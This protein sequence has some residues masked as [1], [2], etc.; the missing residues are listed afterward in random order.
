MSDPQ[1]PAAAYAHLLRPLVKNR[2]GTQADFAKAVFVSTSHLSEIL[3]GRR[4][5]SVK[6]AARIAAEF[7]D[8]PELATLYAEARNFKLPALPPALVDLLDRMAMV[9]RELPY[10]LPSRQPL[11]LSTLYVRQSVSSPAEVRWPREELPEEVGWVE[12]TR[13]ASTLAQPFQDVFEQNDHLVIEGGAGLGKTTLARQL[14]ADLV[15]QVRD[16]QPLI[17]LLLSARVLAK[18]IDGRS[19]GEA[20][21]ASLT[22]EYPGFSDRELRP[23]LFTQDVDGHRWM[24]VVDALDEIPDNTARDQLI[25]LIAGRMGQSTNSTRF[26]ITTRPLELGET[27]RLT[28]AGFFELQPFD[29]EA[30]KRFA[31][32][33]F[34]PRDTT[35]GVVAAD[36]F[37]EQVRTAGLTDVLEVPLL[38]AIA[39]NVHQSDPDSPL[40]ASRYELYVRYIKSYAEMRADADAQALAAL[41]GDDELAWRIGEERMPLLE[42]L[43]L[44][45]MTTETP[46]LDLARDHLAEKDLLPPRRGPKWED[47]LAEWL[48][49]TGLLTRSGGRLRFLHQ[50]F[51]EHL[52]A[53]AKAKQLPERFTPTEPVWDELI[54]G[55][56]LGDEN[57]T[58]VVLHYLYLRDGDAVIEALQRGTL[59]QRERAGELINQGTPC[60][61]ERVRE[62]LSQLRKEAVADD[63]FATRLRNLRGLVG[64]PTV[65]SWLTALL[66]DPA[67]HDELKIT[68]IDLLREHSPEVWRE[69]VPMLVRSTDHTWPSW[70]RRQA[71]KVLAK[72]GDDARD[73]AIRV[74]V[75]MTDK[76]SNTAWDRLYAAGVLAEFGQ[77]ERRTA[78]GVLTV[79][80]TDP[81]ASTH[82]RRTA[83]HDLARLGGA[84]LE[85]AAALLL[86]MV[87][88]PL[89]DI[90]ERVDAAIKLAEVSRQHREP[91]AAV[92]VELTDDPAVD[93]HDRLTIAEAIPSIEPRRHQWAVQHLVR[94]VDNPHLTEYARISGASAL[95]RLGKRHRMSAVESLEAIARDSVVDPYWRL[96]AAETIAELGRAHRPKAVEAMSALALDRTIGE[97]YRC[98]VSEALVKLGTAAYPAAVT[99]SREL[100]T[101]PTTSPAQRLRAGRLLANMGTEQRAEVL[102]WCDSHLS[103][104]DVPADW[105]ASAAILAAGVDP[106]REALASAV[107]TRL[108]RSPALTGAVRAR[109]ARELIRIGDHAGAN[110]ALSD[111]CADPSL[112]HD[113]RR[114]AALR[115]AKSPEKW[116]EAGWSAMRHLA[117]DP[118]IPA[119]DQLWMVFYLQEHRPDLRDEIASAYIPLFEAPQTQLNTYAA[120]LFIHAPATPARAVEALEWNLADLPGWISVQEVFT[121]MAYVGDDERARAVAT[122]HA[123]T[124]DTT[125]P[126]DDRLNTV[127]ALGSL[128]EEERADALRTAR[129]MAEEPRL[130][131][132]DRVNILIRLVRAGERDQAE[133][134]VVQGATVD[135]VVTRLDL[136]EIAVRLGGEYTSIALAELEKIATNPAVHREHRHAALL[137]LKHRHDMVATTLEIL[138]A[139]ASAPPGFR[140][141]ACEQLAR[142]GGD[143]VARAAKSAGTLA[144]HPSSQAA[145][146]IGVAQA[147]GRW[148]GAVLRELINILNLV[149][150]DQSADPALRGQAAQWLTTLGPESYEHGVAALRDLADQPEVDAWNRLWA[151][152]HL[153]AL[154]GEPRSAGLAALERLADGQ[155]DDLVPSLLAKVELVM[156]DD[157][158]AWETFIELNELVADPTASGRVRLEAV[159]ALLRIAPHG[160]RATARALR[161]LTEDPHLGGW[162]RRL[163]ALRLGSF[164]MQGLADAGAALTAL[165]HDETCAVWERTDA[166]AS[167]LRL[168]PVA[169]ESMVD[170]VQ[171]F[172]A[173]DKMP[174]AERRYAAEALLAMSRSSYDAANGVLRALASDPDVDIRERRRA[175]V[176]M[177]EP[178]R[179]RAEGL[180]LLEAMTSDDF[181]AVDRI[182]AW[183]ALVELHNGYL[184]EALSAVEAVAADEAAEPTARRRA[185]ELLLRDSADR[186]DLAVDV[187]KRQ[188]ADLSADDHERALASGL[189]ASRWLSDRAQAGDALESLVPG[190]EVLRKIEVAQALRSLDP[191]H[192]AVARRIL[193][194]VLSDGDD[195]VAGLHVA[196]ALRDVVGA[197]RVISDLRPPRTL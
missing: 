54:R 85:S 146:R 73:T 177:V 52:A 16:A 60:R 127:S 7:P 181:S 31:H 68:V 123:K 183:T 109:I 144:A 45:Y 121:L 159:E 111:L 40:P 140:L 158:R 122:L 75:G 184:D 139:D 59:T 149:T 29:A 26:L 90:S 185:C 98:D 2:P 137:R 178:G 188:A 30:L 99:T 151:A 107:L 169:G 10:L 141:Q 180:A 163:A 81:T 182:E 173:D 1:D 19:W 154:G 8:A 103:G 176:A 166:A 67:V 165:A 32:N 100:L 56:S 161:V 88:S 94:L 21:L 46:L 12:G 69:G 48:C 126:T 61:D 71:A 106:S 187:L 50:T 25:T 160:R 23:A 51:A 38:A 15:E 164:D 124:R 34:N 39:A 72:F 64:R 162:E 14:V 168:D 130:S 20:L 194:D 191:R 115:L 58:R 112:S 24:V 3:A 57:D 114:D 74:L 152:Q 55:M 153:T 196:E 155:P 186:G 65:R 41:A 128:G 138:A 179:A 43:A 172:A 96:R 76:S 143:W 134:A 157:T 105:Q 95:G 108:G 118:T 150:A 136:A 53:S 190:S 193:L 192:Q 97:D 49:Q 79:L 17:P 5:P 147:L 78:A 92:L 195:P 101:G 148:R 171:R 189:L 133:A 104:A 42:D 197:I 113:M 175:A 62:Y 82:Q 129:E 22:E 18:H 110:A 117:F 132:R 120:E 70:H 167:V 9:C 84:H 4:L 80:A 102:A 87:K 170:L 125:R 119:H 47:T 6:D 145:L 93:V 89:L 13:L 142:F 36:H 156:A 83:A 135:D 63:E 27:T 131:R 37:L 35:D 33:W 86:G 116:A 174:W 11:S 28:G 91:A 66:K 44:S 77:A